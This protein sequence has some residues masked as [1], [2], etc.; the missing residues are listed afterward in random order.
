MHCK[1]CVDG[2]IMESIFKLI[3]LSFIFLIAGCSKYDF[4]TMG[5]TSTESLSSEEI[6]SIQETFVWQ[7]SAWSSCYATN[8][9]GPWSDC[10]TSGYRSR[11]CS[12]NEGVQ[13]RTVTCIKSSD[14]TIVSDSFCQDPQ[15]ELTQIC[16]SQ[17]LQSVERE[18]CSPRVYL[19]A[20]CEEGI[21]FTYTDS[22]RP[23]GHPLRAI[24]TAITPRESEPTWERKIV[25]VGINLSSGERSSPSYPARI[26]LLCGTDG[27]WYHYSPNVGF[28]CE[29]RGLNTVSGYLCEQVTEGA[30]FESGVAGCEVPR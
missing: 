10:N 3:F 28:P 2:V 19:P 7:S 9:L 16:I 14:Q 12:V 15:P 6:E 5:E 25:V 1:F 23:E 27:H 13:S 30:V 26:T 4:L 11:T 18:Q 21:H 29:Q 8:A 24:C 20:E 22:N 17:C